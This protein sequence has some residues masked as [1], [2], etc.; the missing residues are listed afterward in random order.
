MDKILYNIE[1][2]KREY[3]DSLQYESNEQKQL[4]LYNM[5]NLINN[6]SSMIQDKREQYENTNIDYNINEIVKLLSI[7]S[8]NPNN[9]Y[10]LKHLTITSTNNILIIG[11]SKALHSLYEDR[12]YSTFEI[13]KKIRNIIERGNSLVVGSSND[14]YRSIIPSDIGVESKILIGK[15]SRVYFYIQ[16][17]EI[18][19]IF[20]NLVNFNAKKLIKRV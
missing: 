10:I 19:D 6:L 1:L 20:N 18:E 9:D 11:K 2:L 5:S 17:N 7:L 3:L 12:S 14:I 15:D 8:Y 16:D 4:S 13:E